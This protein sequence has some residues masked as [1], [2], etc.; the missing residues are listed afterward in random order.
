MEVEASVS[1]V[2]DVDGSSGARRRCGAERELDNKRGC[3]EG[4]E[5]DGGTIESWV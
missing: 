1:A 4:G 3:I 5:V 2:G